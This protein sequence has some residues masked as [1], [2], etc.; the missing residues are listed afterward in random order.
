MSDLRTPAETLIHA[1]A[2]I[3]DAIM[4]AIRARDDSQGRAIAELAT[5]ATG[6]LAVETT[7]AA[8]GVTLTVSLRQAGEQPLM[9]YSIDAARPAP[10]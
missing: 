8:D 6:S 4:D 7:F 9:L 1:A 2:E 10:H 5:S 3:A